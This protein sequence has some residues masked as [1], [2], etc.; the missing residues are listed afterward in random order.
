MYLVHIGL[1]ASTPTAEL[2][3]GTRDLISSVALPQEQVEH[4]SVHPRASS[5]PV[6]GVFLLADRLETA[7]ARAEALLRRAVSSL[8]PLADWRV[9]SA[10]APL[11]APFYEQLLTGSGPV[12]RIRPGPFPSS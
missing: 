5:R 9:G 11:V 2:P 6:V 8:P 1:T 4:I 10:G 12:G 7:E 3:A